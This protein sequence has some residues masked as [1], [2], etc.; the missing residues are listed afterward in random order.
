MKGKKSCRTRRDHGRQKRLHGTS[1]NWDGRDLCGG[2]FRIKISRGIGVKSIHHHLSSL[3]ID[4]LPGGTMKR[5]A[6]LKKPAKA[7]VPEDEEAS[8]YDKGPNDSGYEEENGSKKRHATRTGTN[9]RQE[10]GNRKTRSTAAA[11]ELRSLKKPAASSGKKQQAKG[12]KERVPRSTGVVSSSA[13]E[14]FAETLPVDQLVELDDGSCVKCNQCTGGEMVR[15]DGNHE[16]ENWAHIECV[17][18]R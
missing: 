17:G 10:T 15:C 6:R 4:R 8:A 5:S 9:K 18:L 16:V 13:V 2:S 12:T 1:K 14:E 11:A 3:A 7:T